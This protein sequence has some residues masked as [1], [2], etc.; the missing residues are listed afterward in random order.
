P[1]E[2][3]VPREMLEKKVRTYL[4]ETAA[5]E[6]FWRT[7]L[8]ADMLE[9]EV[10]RMTE[11]SRMPQRLREL[12]AALR[13]DPFTIQECLARPVLVDRLT[14]SFFAYDARIH[15]GAR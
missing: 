14:R 7:R 6:A 8:T 2:E 9:R 12:N 11:Q 1:F 15:A 13:N 5:L 4:K 3:A 10:Q